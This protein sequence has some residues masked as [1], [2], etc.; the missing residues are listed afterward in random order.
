MG[1]EELVVY[2]EADPSDGIVPRRRCYWLNL[3]PLE[4]GWRAR[5][6]RARWESWLAQAVPE[7][8][9]EGVDKMRWRLTTR[10]ALVRRRGEPLEALGVSAAVLG[11]VHFE[12]LEP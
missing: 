12:R 6:T 9:P 4:A 10:W 5:V 7:A 11:E 1:T 3:E 2:L 8:R